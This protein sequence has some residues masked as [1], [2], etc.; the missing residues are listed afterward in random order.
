MFCWGKRSKRVRVSGN[1]CSETLTLRLLKDP[2]ML[3]VHTML[4]IVLFIKVRQIHW[5]KEPTIPS[6]L[7]V[8]FFNLC[9]GLGTG[10]G[11]IIDQLTKLSTTLSRIRVSL[12]SKR[13]K[14]SLKEYL[15][16]GI[17][18]ELPLRASNKS[19]TGFS[20]LLIWTL[21][22]VE[23]PSLLTWPAVSGAFPV[24]RYFPSPDHHI[25]CSSFC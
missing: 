22:S 10:K 5:L 8:F 12:E 7:E 24:V 9:Y 15:W 20:P 21:S 4:S 25:F 17:L 16:W 23:Q 11:R 14:R 13:L 1:Q 18:K 19:S 2:L 3:N 6:I